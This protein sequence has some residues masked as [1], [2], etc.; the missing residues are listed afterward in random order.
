VTGLAV[1][2]LED[3]RR[4]RIA[5]ILLD[6]RTLEQPGEPPNGCRCGRLDRGQSWSLH[7][8]DLILTALGDPR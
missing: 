2:A 1:A 4:Q 8:A 7:L 5:A 6:H 3:P